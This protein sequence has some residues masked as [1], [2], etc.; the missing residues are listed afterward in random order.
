MGINSSKLKSKSKLK[1][2]KQKIPYRDMT[3]D[4]LVEKNKNNI[5]VKKYLEQQKKDREKQ[6]IE[7]AKW[8]AN[9]L[10][11]YK[12]DKYLQKIEKLVEKNMTHSIKIDLN[13]LYFSYYISNYKNTMMTIYKEKII[14]ELRKNGFQVTTSKNNRFR[15]TI[16][17]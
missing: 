2:T 17:W 14:G 10:W 15:F 11:K 3:V 4:T 6:I 9:K 7:E 13:N 5:Q 1:T 16:K 8:R 12:Y